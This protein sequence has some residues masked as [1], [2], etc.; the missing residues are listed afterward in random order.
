MSQ[1]YRSLR[2]TEACDKFLRDTGQNTYTVAAQNL[3]RAVFVFDRFFRDEHQP[4]PPETF[5]GD[6]ANQTE[7]MV[8]G[9]RWIGPKRLAL[10]KEFLGFYHL[11]FRLPV[12]PAYAIPRKTEPTQLYDPHGPVLDSLCDT[13]FD[14]REGR[15]LILRAL[16]ATGVVA[17]SHVVER[18]LRRAHED[19]YAGRLENTPQ[20]WRH[21]TEEY[22]FNLSERGVRNAVG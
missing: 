16:T 14:A 17:H 5:L 19:Y 1:E 9:I 20:G 10:L 21:W 8:F 3:W 7:E 18:A 15:T 13:K 2:L 11:R 22:A 4:D 6:L 12:E